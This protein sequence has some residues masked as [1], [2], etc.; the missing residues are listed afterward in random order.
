MTRVFISLRPPDRTSEV[1]MINYS[2]SAGGVLLN[3]CIINEL[4]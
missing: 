1:A 3:A 4:V 2:C